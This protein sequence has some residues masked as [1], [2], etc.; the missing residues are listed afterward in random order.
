VYLP[1]HKS[2]GGW[3]I[4]EYKDRWDLIEAKLNKMIGFG[5]KNASAVVSTYWSRS[6]QR[7]NRVVLE[8]LKSE[9]LHPSDFAIQEDGVARL[10][11]DLA[12]RAA[13][14]TMQLKLVV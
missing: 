14:L 7:V 11:P 9:A 10:N 8:F 12:R 2:F 1:P 4:S 3:D 13:G 6:G 5:P